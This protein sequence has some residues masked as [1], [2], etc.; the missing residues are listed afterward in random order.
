MLFGQDMRSTYRGDVLAIL[1]RGLQAVGLLSAARRCVQLTAALTN[2]E[3]CRGEREYRSRESYQRFLRFKRAY[4]SVLSQK[5]NGD[6]PGG[7]RAL[8][9][10]CGAP[11][12]EMELGL[13]K[14]LEIAGY[15]PAVVTT[16]AQR[17]DLEYYKLAGVKEFYFWNDFIDQPDIAGADRLVHECSSIQEILQLEV[18]GVRVGKLAVSSALRRYRLGN[19]NVR[20]DQ[21]RG[22]IAQSVAT[23]MRYAKGAQRIVRTA[24][25]GLAL[26]IDGVYSPEGELFDTCLANGVPAISWDVGHKNSSLMFKR[27]T[28]ANRDHHPWSLSRRSWQSIQQMAWTKECRNQLEQELYNSYVSGNW[29]GANG[30]QFNKRL[31]A[32]A[33]LRQRIGLN[34]ERKTV[35]IFPHILW[36]AALF[37]SKCLYDNYEEWLIETVRAACKNDKVNWVIKIHPAHVGKGIVEGFKGEPAEI[38]VLRKHIGKLPGH[39]FLIEAETDINTLSLFPLMDYCVTVCGTI[40]IEA[41]RLGIPVLTAGAGRYSHR[42]FTVDSESREEYQ[43]KLANIQKIPPLSAKQTELAERFAYGTFVLRPLPM[44]TVTLEYP[45]NKQ[46]SGAGHSETQIKVRKTRGWYDAPDLRLLADWITKSDEEDFLLPISSVNHSRL[47]V[48][49][50][51]SEGNVAE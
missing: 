7:K 48:G 49:K 42:G 32:T 47:I 16:S 40:G 26:F 44:R 4:G 12:I 14:C 43:E 19:L 23:S 51:V 31:L 36:D 20:S 28:A 25:P 1:K 5:L 50:L 34:P 11:K 22:I 18:A 6:V 41:A 24:N 10:G 33:E 29:Y 17:L 13:I 46:L 15:V 2:P 35:F 9:F 30:T 38:V 21:D 27:Y 37:W 45:P 8:L 39:I 3:L